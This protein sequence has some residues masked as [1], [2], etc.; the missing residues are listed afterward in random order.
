MVHLQ[1]IEIFESDRKVI[2]SIA[3]L[4]T[5]FQ[6]HTQYYECFKKK[7]Y[8]PLIDGSFLKRMGKIKL[9]DFVYLT[10]VKEAICNK[11]LINI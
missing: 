10:N 4:P 7:L 3:Y 8:L 9:D 2:F 11:I 5:M 1:Y 6:K